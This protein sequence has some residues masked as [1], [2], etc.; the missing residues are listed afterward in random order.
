MQIFF[1]TPEAVPCSR[2]GGLGDVLYHLPRA[3]YKMGHQVTVLVPKHRM[4]E[5]F[6]LIELDSLRR[7]IDLSISRR[8]A[9]FY[10]LTLPE[11]HDV[12]L[13][14]CDDFF[15]RPGIYGNEF[16]DYDDNS[17]R[18]IFFSKAAFTAISD[19][20]APSSDPVLVHSHDWPTGLV[21]MYFKV[22]GSKTPVG[23]VFT[24]HN[25][26]NQ[27]TFPYFDFT[28]TGL[29]WSHFTLQGLEFH[30]QVNLTKAGLLGAN[31]IST[32]S[33]RYARETLG[34]E[35]GRGLEG[36]IKERRPNLRSVI[37]G[38][39][40][41]L[42]DPAHDRYLVAPFDPEDLSGKS[43]CRDCLTTLFGLENDDRPIV[44]V[45]SRFLARKGLDLI[46]RAMPKL[47]ELP[48][49]LIFMGTG[50]DYF[51][52]VLRETASNNPGQVGLKLSYD[53]ALTHQILGGAD[54]LLVPS[55][56]EPCGLEQLYA[57]KY[58]TVPV[59]RATGG[60]DDTVLDELAMSSRG[61]GFKFID[62]TPEALIE[63]LSTAIEH[64]RDPQ[65]WRELMLRCMSED[66]SWE[67]AASAYVEIYQQAYTLATTPA[68]INNPASGRRVL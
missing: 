19:L 16:G 31:I 52:S 25:L 23:T 14:G 9:Q 65:S 45:V 59:V 49:K 53:P 47:L 35:L 63:A 32:V 42:W 40:Y 29:D 61:T 56:F 64:F 34:P 11:A 60:L 46:T 5:E 51:L 38:V 18:F 2:A 57:L 50:E 27:G 37:H 33:H 13:V 12:I 22:Y 55:R 36:V 39:D 62:Y 10:R 7:E 48:L 20:I 26:A 41:K 17:E 28:M 58:G 24:Y 68:P 44:A 67:R 30:G 15:D 3:L 4:A 8:S 1:V 43:A 66:Y 21:P 54:I 6:Q